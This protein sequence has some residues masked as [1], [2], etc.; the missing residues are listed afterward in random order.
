MRRRTRPTRAEQLID[1]QIDASYRRTCT[2][3]QID[4]M[5][6][7]TI[8]KIGRAAIKNGAT[9]AELDTTIKDFVATLQ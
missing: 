7:P 1:A 6:I 4:M 2:G 3:I 8:F 5:A 9:E